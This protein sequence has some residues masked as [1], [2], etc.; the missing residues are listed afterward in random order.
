MVPY[1]EQGECLRISDLG[2]VDLLSIWGRRSREHIELGAS[3]RP[4]M[5]KSAPHRSSPP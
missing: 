4:L 2:K 3:H 5:D 1:L